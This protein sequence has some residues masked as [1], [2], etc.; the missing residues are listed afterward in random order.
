MLIE[1]W[2]KRFLEIEK[3]FSATKPKICLIMGTLLYKKSAQ[4]DIDSPEEMWQ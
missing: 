4:H 1:Y 3:V 2:N